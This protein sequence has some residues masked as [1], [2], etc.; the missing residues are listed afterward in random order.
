MAGESPAKRFILVGLDGVGM[1]SMLH[2]VEAGYMPNVGRLIE[3]GVHREMWGVLP[4]LTPPGWTTLVTGAWPG[5]HQ[6][7]DFNIRALG[8]PLDQ[9]VWGINTRLCKAEYL[10]NTVERGGREPVLVKYEMSWPPTISRGVQVE[11][12]GP[13]ISNH[14]QIAGYHL[15][16]VGR[17]VE[18]TAASTDSAAVD[19]S[20]LREE[21]RFE[22]ITLQRGLRQW[23]E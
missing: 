15:F 5:T 11:G 23:V 12:T 18:Q 2:M 14:A 22:P 1:E 16:A 19:P 3:R 6:V 7:M 4:T 13:G 8:K 20:A 9:T 10:W 17:E 21:Q